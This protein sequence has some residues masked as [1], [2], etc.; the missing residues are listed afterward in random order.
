MNNRMKFWCKNFT[1]NAEPFTLYRFYCT[2]E[3]SQNDCVEIRRTLVPNLWEV[4]QIY[5]QDF[6]FVCTTQEVQT[7]LDVDN[8][9]DVS[10]YSY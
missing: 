3:C 7:M 4:N 8:F 5:G 2:E 9:A 1:R 6:P 10:V